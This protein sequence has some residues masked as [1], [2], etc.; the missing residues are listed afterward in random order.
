MIAH[1]CTPDDCDLSVILV[2]HLFLLLSFSSGVSPNKTHP[3]IRRQIM[4]TLQQIPKSTIHDILKKNLKW[5]PFKFMN[6]QVLEQ[7]H[8]DDQKEFCE[9]IL[10]QPDDF[11]DK[12]L[13]CVFNSP[14]LYLILLIAYWS[15]SLLTDIWLDIQ[16]WT[17]KPCRSDEKWWMLHQPNN[18]QNDRVWKAVNPYA[19]KAN[20][21]QG[22]LK[23]SIKTCTLQT[24]IDILNAH[25]GQ[26]I[27]SFVH[28]PSNKF[29]QKL[30]PSHDLGLS[31]NLKHL[32]HFFWLQVLTV[33]WAGLGWLD[34]QVIPG[35]SKGQSHNL[36]WIG[37]G[38]NFR[39]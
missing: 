19:I 36:P 34:R 3:P 25:C 39:C 38:N 6:V 8:I 29:E 10:Q 15:S 13:W 17:V 1:I 21:K 11:P 7:K 37:A 5:T 30:D 32:L 27:T 26:G 9:W 16:I 33:F 35:W 22:D 2:L 31:L 4:H 18:R 12:V 20:K 14:V 24:N 23:R 28:S